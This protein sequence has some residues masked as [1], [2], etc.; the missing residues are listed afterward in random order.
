MPRT[1]KYSHDMPLDPKTNV[2]TGIICSGCG[3]KIYG[4]YVMKQRGDREDNYH[5]HCARARKMTLP[6]HIRFV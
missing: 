3:M 6:V 1:E 4:E 2:V 5:P